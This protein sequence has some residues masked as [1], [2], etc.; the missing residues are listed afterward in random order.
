MAC[1]RFAKLGVVTGLVIPPAAAYSAYKSG[2]FDKPERIGFA[3]LGG[4]VGSASL[5]AGYGL[6]QETRA[7]YFALRQMNRTCPRMV[8]RG[9]MLGVQGLTG[10]AL[11][12]AGGC[13]LLGTGGGLYLLYLFR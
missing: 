1:K 6:M 4:G 10:A 5:V 3:V 8:G 13:V 2:L 11:V 9:V 12:I 7:D